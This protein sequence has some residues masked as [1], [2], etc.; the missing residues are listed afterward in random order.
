MI[1]FARCAAPVLLAPA[2]AAL[3]MAPGPAQAQG[4]ADQPRTAPPD[5]LLILDAS[6]SMWGQIDGINKIVIARDVVEQVVRSMPEDQRL[7]LVAY[8]HRRKGDCRDIE[9]LADV[10]ADRGEVIEAV[11]ALSPR[12]KTPLSASV[13]HAAL[14]LDY[15]E[16]AA[17]VILVSDGLENCE[18][19][20]CALAALL[21]EK[22][23]DFT[24]HVVGF[25]VTEEE[26]AGLQCIAEGTGGTFLAADTAHE[27]TEALDSLAV[28]PAPE[29]EPE[30]EAA[31]VEE[32][33]AEPVP[34]E[35]ILKATILPGGPLIQSDLAW[36]I[37]DDT[38][39][40]VF[41]A[42]ATG[43]AETALPPG[44]YTVSASWTGWDDGAPKTGTAEITIAPQSVTVTTV[45][46]DLALPV[47]L[48]APDTAAEGEMIDVTWTGPDELGARIS[49]NG[50]EDAP[51][52][53]IY[54][55]PAGAA[56]TDLAATSALPMPI[57]PGTYELR[58]TLGAPAIVLA[59][60]TIEITDSDYALSA[61]ASVPISTPVAI[62]WTGPLTEGDLVTIVPAGSEEVFDNGRYQT[63]VDGQ[64]ASIIAPET[65]GDY[66]IR[67]VMSGAYT[68]YE[69]QSRT[70][71]ASVP[72]VVE[73]VGAS[74]AVPEVAKGG[75][76]IEVAWSG[77]PEEWED[78]VLTV[79]PPGGEKLNRDS[80]ITL[81]QAG[82]DSAELRMPAV[83]GAYEVV[84][85]VNPGRRILARAPIRIEAAT[86]SVTAPATVTAGEDFELSYT[87][88]GF[89]GDRV[90]VVPA[91]AP[92]DK[93]WSVNSNYGF[94]ADPVSDGGTGTV[95]GRIVAKP[96]AYE[97]RYV[98]GMQ[99]QVLARAPLTVVE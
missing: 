19:D 92:D 35:L 60:R 45:P 6:G 9:T 47:T 95:Q 17:R 21:A 57:T 44:D 64:P 34:S 63:L 28:P 36:T 97:A 81:Y 65:P 5:A 4:T 69:G 78:D 58:Y 49:V 13:E 61:P 10:G 22:G 43:V 27:L 32:T 66:E 98:T 77:P 11:R 16:Q 14:A 18:A 79:V 24:V 62:D 52:D 75:S 7:G 56:T 87:G 53:H 50:P 26:R 39:A 30:A 89:E 40:Q 86:A 91:D 85:M 12:G 33:G 76:T 83:P 99:D 29:P 96:G 37:T 82:I 94:P 74:V 84:Y 41:E 70:V 46:I 2:L 55:L 68:T 90:V 3:L 59:R 48:E 42:S 1:R 8:G 23:L 20:P 31:P 88:D 67:Y 80:F 93:M 72:L 51:A 54:F 15:T 73:T 71:Q 38:G 25:D